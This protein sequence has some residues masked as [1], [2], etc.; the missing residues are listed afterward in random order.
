MIIESLN[1]FYHLSCFRCYVCNTTLGNGNQ[2]ADV[3]VRDTKLH[4]Q[5]CYSN[6]DDGMR[7][8]QV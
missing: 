2:G 6:D 1:L 7:Y 3:R 8:S 4:C 5:T